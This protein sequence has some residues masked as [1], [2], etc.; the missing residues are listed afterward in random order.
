MSTDVLKPAEIP[1][2]SDSPAPSGWDP[3]TVWRERVHKPRANVTSVRAR[4]GEELPL[5]V[6]EPIKQG[7]GS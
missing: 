2:S 6:L 4:V 5:A 7:F 1:A 3:F